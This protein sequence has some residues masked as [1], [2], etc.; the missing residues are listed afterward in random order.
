MSSPRPP[1]R[2]QT[3]EALFRAQKDERSELPAWCRQNRAY[4]PAGLSL[5][6]VPETLAQ[7]YVDEMKR[8]REAAREWLE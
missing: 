8:R 2:A 1:G 5:S 3:V 4:W 6:E 7:L